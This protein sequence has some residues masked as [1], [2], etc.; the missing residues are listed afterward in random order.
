QPMSAEQSV[1]LADFARTCKAAARAVSL[2]PGT[3]PAIAATLERLAVA[4]DKIAH[5]GDL[6]LTIHPAALAIHDRAPLRPDP[7]IAELAALLHSRLIGE[8][9]IQ[10]GASSEDWRQ[11][12]LVLAK[13]VEELLAEGGPA[14][15]W[16]ATGR[17]LFDIIEI[18]YA[19]VLKER[20]SGDDATWDRLLA[21][22]LKGEDLT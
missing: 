20:T 4:V 11:L 7:A 3:H 6:T 18:D 5:G 8:L 2:Y 17:G 16:T 21:S 19:A 22:C 12:L 15:V 10:P 9:R 1:A 14:A 13:P